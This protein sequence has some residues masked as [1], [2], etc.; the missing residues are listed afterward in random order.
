MKDDPTPYD[1]AVSGILAH[2]LKNPLAAVLM[3]A[4]LLLAAEGKRERTLGARILASGERM[5]RMIDQLV[6]WT[7]VRGA[8]GHLPLDRA[9]CDLGALADVAV[10]ELRKSP[11]APPIVVEKRG[12]LHGRWDVGRLAQGLSNL[13]RNALEHATSPGVTVV[14]D[15]LGEDVSFS[16]ENEGRIADAVLPVL[17]EPL[18]G[19]ASGSGVRGRGLGLGLY[20]T[21][22]IV[23]AHGGRIDVDRSTPGRVA[24]RVTLPRSENR[25]AQGGNAP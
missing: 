2:D 10:A 21:R 12:A 23:L 13:L 6:E 8:G 15:G 4:R 17:F 11:D 18:R 24:F 5:S 19:R 16:V 22:E 7:R 25:G 9:E 20:L 1:Q 3:N 14:L